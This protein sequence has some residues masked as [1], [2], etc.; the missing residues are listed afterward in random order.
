[1]IC[2]KIRGSPSETVLDRSKFELAAVRRCVTW[3]FVG[4]VETL[5]N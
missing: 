4:F 3:D 2:R 5:N 1:V